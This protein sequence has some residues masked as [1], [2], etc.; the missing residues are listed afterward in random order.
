MVL[1]SLI[2]LADISGSYEENRGK[3]LNLGEGVSKRLS[4]RGYK[5]IRSY[6]EQ[7]SYNI[8]CVINDKEI[9]LTLDVPDTRNKEFSIYAG[10]KAHS[11]G[12][13]ERRPI[14]GSV[15]A[16]VLSVAHEQGLSCRKV[17]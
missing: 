9:I 1:Q 8:N 2:A 10:V 13:S 6:A 17:A 11:L 7:Y 5:I 4:E 3:I 16:K 12:D 15:L 14:M